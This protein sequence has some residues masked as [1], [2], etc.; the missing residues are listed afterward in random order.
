MIMILFSTLIEE[1]RSNIH[2]NS[3]NLHRILKR[4]PNIAYQKVN[5]LALFTGSRYNL[6][7]QLHFPDS[8]KISDID[9]YGTEN[10]GIVVDKFRRT[11]PIP[12]EEI[13]RMAIEVIGNNVQ[14]HDAYMYEGKEGIKVILEKGRMEIL[15]GSI[16]LWCKADDEKI[17]SYVDWLM[18]NVYFR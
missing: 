5:E 13:K 17:K 14:A 6:N 3:E 11:F 9:S 18:Q 8:K 12:R 15:P 4:S 1:L 2:N 7:L 10:I 16:H